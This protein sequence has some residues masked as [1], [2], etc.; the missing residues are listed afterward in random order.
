MDATSYTVTKALMV[1]GDAPDYTLSDFAAPRPAWQAQG[2]C[3]GGDQV[4]LFFV[5]RGGDADPAKALCDR[6]PVLAQCYDFAMSDPTL[7]GF[8]A[9]TSEQGRQRLRREAAAAA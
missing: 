9:G 6:C 7:R 2:A 4:D 1:A 5:G 8:W 3:S